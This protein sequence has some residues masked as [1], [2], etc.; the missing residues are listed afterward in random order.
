[1]PNPKCFNNHMGLWLLEPTWMG[2]AVGAIKGG[3]YPEAAVVEELS[4]DG[5]PYRVIGGV[6]VLS[7]AGVIMKGHSKYGGTSSVELR[8]Q[9][10]AATMDDQVEAILMMI[11]SPGGHVAGTHELAQEVARANRVKPIT[12]QINDLGASAAYWVASQADRIV[13]NLTAEVG[14]IGVVAVVHDTSGAYEKEGVKVH[15]VSTGPL[16]GAFTDGAPVTEAMLENLQA[17]VND[18]N[19]IFLDDIQSK[20]AFTAPIETIATGETFSSE[21]ALELN[22]IDAISDEEATLENIISG[23]KY[24]KRR[25]TALAQLDRLSPSREK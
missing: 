6:A 8:R 21:K 10:R 4:E 1:M 23:L 7:V 13:A 20:R 16:K 18:L 5:G 15:V 19:K 22:L 12:A 14:S 25:S 17:R 9:L 24:K 3:V 2:Q 11:D